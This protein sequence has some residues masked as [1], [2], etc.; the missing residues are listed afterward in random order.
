MAE[1]GRGNEVRVLGCGGLGN[2]L[3]SWCVTEFL[4]HPGKKNSFYKP[5][6]WGQ[7]DNPELPVWLLGLRTGV[8][9]LSLSRGSSVGA[10]AQVVWALWS[11]VLVGR[12]EFSVMLA[13]CA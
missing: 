1:G 2:R 10:R 13:G 5:R 8:S 6:V 3:S 12:A 4:E 11:C 7:L 9:S